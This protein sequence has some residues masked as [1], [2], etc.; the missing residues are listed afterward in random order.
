MWNVAR[1]LP[2]ASLSRSLGAKAIDPGLRRDTAVHGS[3]SMRVIPLHDLETNPIPDTAHCESLNSA[4]AYPA[5]ETSQTATKPP[6]GQ[7]GQACTLY[8]VE[9]LRSPSGMGEFPR[10]SGEAFRRPKCRQRL[11]RTAASGSGA[12]ANR[13]PF[14]G[15]A[16]RPQVLTRRERR[17]QP[18]RRGKPSPSGEGGSRNCGLPRDCVMANHSRRIRE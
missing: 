16:V 1:T 6:P 9:A 14:G 7:Q 10:L 8:F 11:R 2:R 4:A 18:T 12:S 3:G 17:L 5:P 15:L 13:P